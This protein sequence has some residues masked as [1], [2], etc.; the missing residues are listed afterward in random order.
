MSKLVRICAESELPDEGQACELSF[1]ARQFCVARSGGEISVMDNV[2]PHQEGP[3]GQ[4]LV[5]NGRVVCP[6]HAW[7]FDVKTGEAQHTDRARVTVYPAK[8]ENG[9]LMIELPEF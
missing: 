1:H 7:A 4:G 2:C 6:W 9:A 8:I 5:E 3:L